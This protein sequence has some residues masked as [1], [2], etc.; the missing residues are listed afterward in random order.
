MDGDPT[1][2]ACEDCGITRHIRDLRS[3]CPICGRTMV[4][5]PGATPSDLR[6]DAARLTAIAAWLRREGAAGQDEC[7]DSGDGFAVWL[8]YSG[9]AEEL[10]RIAAR[11]SSLK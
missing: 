5:A 11:L 2:Y 8:F 7:V 3:G 9:H 1:F 10:D 4:P 6:E